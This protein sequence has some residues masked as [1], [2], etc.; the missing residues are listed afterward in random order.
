M[1][2]SDNDILLVDDLDDPITPSSEES[3]I[4]SEDVLDAEVASVSSVSPFSSVFSSMFESVG[5]IFNRIVSTL[6][7]TAN[8]ASSKA[9]SIRQS[10]EDQQLRK[11]AVAETKANQDEMVL[12]A[13][14]VQSFEWEIS[15]MDCPDCATKANQAVS[16]IDG[17][18]SCDV[19]VMEGKISI[20]VD[21]SL[22]AVSRISRVLDSIGF[23]SKRPW[24]TVQGVTPKMVEDNRIIDRRTVRREILNVPGILD[25]QMIDGQIQIKR[26]H[27]STSIMQNDLREGLLEIIGIEPILTISKDGS[28]RS[29]QWQLLGALSTVPVLGIIL[30][31][32]S[33]EQLFVAQVISFASVLLIGWPMLIGAINSIMNRVF[34]FQILTTA[35]VVGAM[36]LQEYSEALMVVGL[37]SFAAH[38]EENAI[39]KARESMQ[40]GLDRLPREAR[41]V[42]SEKKMKFVEVTPSI[43]SLTV[44]QPS[45]SSPS[46][47]SSSE[48]VPIATL[49][50]GDR[51]EI[52]SGEVVPVDGRVI[53]GTGH[54]DRAPLTGESLPV[55]I[56]V[57]TSVEAGLTLT[58]GPVIVE[59]TAIEEDTRLAGL[60]DM[61]HKFKERPPRVHST[62]E[63]FTKWWVPLV[64]LFSPTIGLLAH[65]Q[66]EQAV[67]TTLLLWVVS[68][69]CALLLASPIPHAIALSHASTKGIV[70]RGGDVLEKA[71]R[72]D[73][74]FLDKTG[75]LTSGQPRLHSIVLAN[76]IE[77]LRTSR[78]AAGLEMR[79]NHPYAN[80]IINSLGDGHEPMNVT[81]IQDGEAGV[82][83]KIRGK[84]VKIGRVDWLEESGIKIP[85]ELSVELDEVREAGH[86]VS[87]LS[88][89]GVAIALFRFVH[90]D[91]RDGAMELVTSLRQFGIEVQILSGDEQKAVESFGETLG[92]RANQCTGNVSPEEKA[93][94]VEKRSA[95]RRT[96]MAGDGFNDSGALAVADVGIAVGSGDQVNLEAADVLIP[97]EDPRAVIALTTLARSTRRIVQ[98]NIAL[99]LFLTLTLVTCVLMGVEISITAGVLLHEA[100]AFFVIL[101]G[102]WV[103]GSGFQRITTVADIFTDV[104]KE[105]IHSIMI[106]LGKDV[107]G[108]STP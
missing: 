70:A 82:I 69:P 55:K 100:S 86:G 38:L 64:L 37:V 74:A 18:E 107:D 72:V 26:V 78:L 43:G 85:K 96:L 108:Q 36:A 56:A 84:E 42:G 66:T 8:S 6:K 28:L 23:S 73:L 93:S 29:D 35:A 87:M 24:E 71:A 62:I 57:G 14:K 44:L 10:R 48:M 21:L 15:G 27:D 97:G 3:T 20:D 12:V 102:M 17:V 90:D 59:T 92:I 89:D 54:L 79:S 91:A 39:I 2:D 51:I 58:R 40:G 32:E 50:I 9:K 49:Q 53:E 33:N 47:C 65:G 106:L 83:G 45:S 81:S 34:A 11:S 98:V 68:C 25:V 19:S 99:S 80:V 63:S 5:S 101:N 41:L 7:S 16:R 88:E 1:D 103:A 31:L 77:M 60:I 94:Y 75:T 52:R 30:L 104:F 22:T 76:G 105:A 95:S 4:S 13:A 46:N 61:V 67:L